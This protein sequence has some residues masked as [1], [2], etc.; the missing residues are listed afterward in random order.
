MSGP[1]S[2]QSARPR[3]QGQA[4]STSRS[5]PLG[6]K[7]PIHAV[8]A[9]G[10]YASKSLRQT[11][12][13]T[14]RTTSTI[15]CLQKGSQSHWSHG[16]VYPFLLD[17]DFPSGTADTWV[18]EDWDEDFELAKHRLDTAREAGR[19]QRIQAQER[20]RR[21][22]ERALMQ[23]QFIQQREAEQNIAQQADIEA[24]PVFTHKRNSVRMLHQSATLSEMLLA[25]A[26]HAGEEDL[27]PTPR[28]GV[29]SRGSETLFGNSKTPG[30]SG[31]DE[32]VVGSLA[33]AFKAFASAPIEDIMPQQPGSAGHR[34][35]RSSLCND[36]KEPGF[37]WKTNREERMDALR[38]LGASRQ[39]QC[40]L[41][42]LWQAR[43]LEF[44]DLPR[45]EQVALHK[46]FLTGAAPGRGGS[47]QRSHVPSAEA[48]GEE[49]K[50]DMKGL[51]RAL[52]D[53]GLESRNTKAKAEVQE[54]C[55]E[56][57]ITGKVDFFQFSFE[58]VPHVRKILRNIRRDLVRKHFQ[59]YDP[60][61]IGYLSKSDCSCVVEQLFAL[62]MDRTSLEK[63]L[64]FFE[65]Q[66]AK[67]AESDIAFE[68]FEDL[69]SNVQEHAIRSLRE[70]TESIHQRE[71][72]AKCDLEHRDRN[73]LLVFYEEFTTAIGGAAG[74]TQK[75]AY[76]LLAEFGLRSGPDQEEEF[77][78]LFRN[79]ANDEDLL[80]FPGL[81]RIIRWARRMS[82][83][84]GHQIVKDKFQRL[85]RPE[86]G[87]LPS[88][89]I[90]N[91][92]ASIG[93]VPRCREDQAEI[94]RLLGEVQTNAAG[95]VDLVNLQHFGL[96]VHERL[97][98]AQRYRAHKTAVGLQLT[99]RDVAFYKEIFH[100]FD[101]EGQGSLDA[102]QVRE[103][104][105]AADVHETLA[106]VE[107][108]MARCSL[109]FAIEV[110]SGDGLTPTSAG[111]R[112]ARL[113]VD[114]DGFLNLLS[115]FLGLRM[116]TFFSKCP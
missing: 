90:P 45:E 51:R 16:A 44:E 30:G 29:E 26:L 27:L 11:Q 93:L 9:G 100:D 38:Q 95:E 3:S 77:N 17:V 47:K 112:A 25:D 13:R 96:S 101:Q 54:F 21:Q 59:I 74:L 84:N 69:I 70:P 72:L 6:R 111:A 79:G 33:S 98:A 41:A 89:S 10:S 76:V 14:H 4:A 105:D 80:V 109:A 64:G 68:V 99:Q 73:E 24:S 81:L 78:Q 85:C 87:G 57:V 58:A 82:I 75:Q 5:K 39:R 97:K 36:P 35:H 28:V 52:C 106:N 22:R 50:L 65:T 63:I 40:K 7:L 92:L 102:E 19:A 113:R 12:S 114:F 31:L 37:Q 43:R 48:G 115:K 110:A 61:D 18:W 67:V 2:Q 8:T 62:E 23:Q 53:F 32:S 108:G 116:T 107:A 94:W 104:L 46:A 49:Q 83:T 15:S 71:G 55:G 34:S 56:L 86:I 91:L 66:L 1:A 60:E 88:S 42:K 103:V 20:N